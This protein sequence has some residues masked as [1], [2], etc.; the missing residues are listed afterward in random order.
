MAGTGTI[1]LSVLL[2]FLVYTNPTPPHLL[3]SIHSL[4]YHQIVIKKQTEI[5]GKKLEMV[6]NVAAEMMMMNMMILIMLEQNKNNTSRKV[7]ITKGTGT[8]ICI[9]Y[10]FYYQWR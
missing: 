4:E 10:F 7:Q 8:K 1:K 3:L 9:Q 6:C 2:L 5:G